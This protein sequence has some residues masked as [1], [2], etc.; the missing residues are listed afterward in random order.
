MSFLLQPT[1]S[2]NL[3][4]ITKILKENFLKGI[5]ERN[6]L[7]ILGFDHA[8]QVKMT[9]SKLKGEVLCKNRKTPPF[10]YLFFP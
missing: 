3:S 2:S 1:S 9:F 6:L 10:I 5:Q 8:L 4:H 7:I